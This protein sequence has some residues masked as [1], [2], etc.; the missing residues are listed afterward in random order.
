MD[1]D[2]LCDIQQGC[3]AWAQCMHLVFSTLPSPQ[4]SLPQ[5][6]VAKVDDL[7]LLHKLLMGIGEIAKSRE[8]R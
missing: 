8:K 1:L 6:L 2:L 4:P 5:T 3:G 7:Q